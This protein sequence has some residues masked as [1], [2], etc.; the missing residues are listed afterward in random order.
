MQTT[1]LEKITII[2]NEKDNKIKV[3]G[4]KIEEMEKAKKKSIKIKTFY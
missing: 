3:L 4:N 2:I 1:L